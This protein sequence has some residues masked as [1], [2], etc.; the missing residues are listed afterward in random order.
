MIKAGSLV[1]V[2]KSLTESVKNFSYLE[3]I[4]WLPVCDEQTLYTVRAIEQRK[5]GLGVLLEE[6]VIGFGLYSGIEIAI[7]LR[8]V[9]EVQPPMQLTEV[10]ECLKEKEFELV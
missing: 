3:T 9:I 4:L 2:K 8:H 6:G 7:N 5:K 1:V 10:E